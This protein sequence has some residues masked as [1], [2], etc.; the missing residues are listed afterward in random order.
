MSKILFITALLAIASLSNAMRPTTPKNPGS[1]AIFDKEIFN[2]LLANFDIDKTPQDHDFL[3]PLKLYYKG[4]GSYFSIDFTD[5]TK[6][7]NN[8]SALY[9]ISLMHYIYYS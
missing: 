8:T 6:C 1:K 2:K 7:F 9:Q 4:L 5:Q 3:T